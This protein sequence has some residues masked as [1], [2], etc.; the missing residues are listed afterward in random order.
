MMKTII[1]NNFLLWLLLF[2]LAF[3]NGALREIVIKKFVKET[4]AH[5]LSALTAIFFFSCAVLLCWSRTGIT[6][7]SQ[8]TIVGIL[9]LV[10]TLL[11]EIFLLNRIISKLSWKE[12]AATY[13]IFKGESWPYVLLWLLVLPHLML[14]HNS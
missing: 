5:H 4:L 9:W 8:A 3:V 12:I 11:T 6:N 1:I 13:N 14:L 10:L 2:V 7:H